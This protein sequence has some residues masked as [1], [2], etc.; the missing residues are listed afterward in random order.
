MKKVLF[1]LFAI[2]ILSGCSKFEGTWCQKTEVFS[3]LVILN[4][5]YTTNEY[6]NI[7]NKIEK[8]ESLKNYDVV[9]ELEN[10]N[11]TINIYFNNKAGMNASEEVLSNLKGINKI[12]TK[13]FVVVSQKLN[14]VKDEY[15]YG[16]NLDNIDAAIYKGRINSDKDTLILGDFK[17][18]YKDKLLC[19]DQECTSF[20]TKSNECE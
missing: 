3:T 18:Y 10:G 15:V 5:K 13:S 11:T 1:L 17:L 8:L 9:D 12:E 16:L 2:F 6:K 20:L 19:L 4:E 14:I 7:I